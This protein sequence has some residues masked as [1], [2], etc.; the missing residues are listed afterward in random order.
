M[1]TTNEMNPTKKFLIGILRRGL[2]SSTIVETIEMMDSTKRNRDE[3]SSLVL[4]ATKDCETDEE[5]L[6]AVRAIWERFMV[7]D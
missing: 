6:T 2:S 1:P 3:I 4:K 7:G 5:Y